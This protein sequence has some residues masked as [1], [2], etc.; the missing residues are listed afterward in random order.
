MQIHNFTTLTLSKC[1]ITRSYSLG[2]KVFG[3]YFLKG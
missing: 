2:V 3:K 1:Q